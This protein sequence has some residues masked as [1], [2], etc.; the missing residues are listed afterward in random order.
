MIE[1]I[2]NF[3]T[4]QKKRF[5][6]SL[7]LFFY[8][9]NHFLCFSHYIKILLSFTNLKNFL[10]KLLTLQAILPP[11][12]LVTSGGLLDNISFS[13][14]SFHFFSSSDTLEEKS[15]IFFSRNIYFIQILFALFF[16]FFSPHSALHLL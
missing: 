3:Y 8:N 9:L 6:L 10:K 2:T 15:S 1:I 7:F 4:E 16:K 11:P 14:I 13:E 12:I 5:L